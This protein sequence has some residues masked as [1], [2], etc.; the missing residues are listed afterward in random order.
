M[1]TTTELHINGTRLR[2]DAGRRELLSVLRDD[3]T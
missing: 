3:W 2:I 1:P